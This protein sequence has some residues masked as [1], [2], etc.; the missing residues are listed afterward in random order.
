MS[1][2][3]KVLV[4]GSA[5]FEEE[6]FKTMIHKLMSG[7]IMVNRK[8]PCN[9]PSPGGRGNSPSRP[10]PDKGWGGRGSPFQSPPVKGEESCDNLGKKL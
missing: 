2:V 8:T 3:A 6:F 5:D 1:K 9:S 7:K 4:I 10:S